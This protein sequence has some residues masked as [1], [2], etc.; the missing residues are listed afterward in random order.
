MAPSPCTC[1]SDYIRCDSKQLSQVPVFS[2]H[3]EQYNNIYLHLESNQLTSI[4]AYAFQNLSAINASYVHVY[5]AN[6]HIVNI[7]SHAFSGIEHAV[8]DLDL[9]NN[10]LTHLPQ[11]LEQLSALRS[12][13][14]LDNPLAK[15]DATV[16]T[17]LSSKLT[18]LS[19][20][21]GHFPS[22]PNELNVLRNLSSLVIHD[23]RFRFA[24]SPVFHVFEN[25]L[26]S[27]E[28]SHTDF[29]SI[30]SAVCRLKVLRRF[31]LNYSPNLSKHNASIF[32]ECTHNMTTVISLRLQYN[33]LTIF[34]QIVT[35]FPNLQ[36]LDLNNNLL[37]F[38]E[39][40]SFMGSSSLTHIYLGTNQFTSV[41]SAINRATNL[42]VLYLNNNQIDTV[43]EF[44]LL[45]LHK[46][47]AIY[48]YSNPLVYLSPHAF[49]HSPLLLLVGL[50]NTRLSHVPRA[51]LS[52]KHLSTL[53]LSGTSLEC[54]CDAMSYLKAWNVSTISIDAW[55]MSG[56][57]V[58]TYLTTDLPHCA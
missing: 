45:R 20:S 29:E 52:L 18:S 36:S 7:E 54:S 14:L 53:Y 58:K 57:Y 16:L 10:N 3:N 9:A 28:M 42:Q 40:T 4:P 22:F 19:V 48:L 49:T 2:R 46:L 56:K 25:Q 24:H 44:D 27:L 6:N 47:M 34:P 37:H 32:D 41:P 17:N 50:E 15:L 33:Q 11:A 21:I 1:N 43:E 12:L 55:C 51:L 35:V 13:Y 38:I 26:H 31:A 30:P 23:I 5:L 39:N 8:T